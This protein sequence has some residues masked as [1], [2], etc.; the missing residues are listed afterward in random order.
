MRAWI[1]KDI[2]PLKKEPRWECELADEVLFGMP[3]DILG[4]EV[5][6]WYKIKTHY[7]YEGYMHSSQFLMDGLCSE[8]WLR[9]EKKMVIK[10]YGDVLAEPGVQGV[11]LQGLP[12]GS[13][14]TVGEELLEE[15]W[16][17]VILPNGIEGFTRIENLI[18]MPEKLREEEA[19]R[20]KLVQMA[21]LYE[22]AQYRWGGKTTQGLDCSG[23]CAMAYMLSGILIYR[24][25]VIVEGFPLVEIPKEEMKKGDLLF[26]PGHVAM[27]IQGGKYIHSSAGRN[28]VGYDSLD[29]QDEN[30][31][32][33]LHNNFLK[34]ASIFR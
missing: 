20:E 25:A 1:I 5:G 24:D 8:N 14:I 3:I 15:R 2:A 16:Q 19:L 27:Y 4:H 30:Y 7:H 11:F 31:N 10:S 29:P 22:G 34:A 32:A 9:G 18:S 28:G 23:L 12:R 26:F 33:D 13:W 21:R 17:R 6:A